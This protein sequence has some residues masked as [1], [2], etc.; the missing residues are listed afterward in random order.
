MS[1]W[2]SLGRGKKTKND[3]YERNLSTHQQE[4]LPDIRARLAE[5]LTDVSE[6]FVTFD[7]DHRILMLNE[8]MR[9]RFGIGSGSVAGQTVASVFEA[10]FAEQLAADG[11]H[12]LTDHRGREWPCRATRLTS[13]LDGQSFQTLI[14]HDLS[15]RPRPD[16]E[17]QLLAAAAR[18]TENAVVI[19]DPDG[20]V[21]FVNKGFEKLAGYRLEEVKGTKPGDRLQGAY[22]SQETRR[23]IRQH[24]DARKPFYEEI[25][26]YHKNG[27]PYWIS[28]AI[29]PIFNDKG[30][31]TNF[32]ALEADV[33]ATKEAALI[34]G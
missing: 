33:T 12:C 21:I 30:I 2:F 9:K 28:L 5:L 20:Q 6:P 32:V 7:T 3:V 25:L 18:V 10:D 22:T 8:S 17:D 13:R 14:L 24:L 31:L 27:E 26:N 19:T 23:R 16:P 11:D 1:T 34:T 4:P 15:S 29:N